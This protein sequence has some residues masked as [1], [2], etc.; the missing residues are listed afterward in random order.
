MGVAPQHHHSHDE[1]YPRIKRATRQHSRYVSQLWFRYLSKTTEPNIAHCAV[2]W[3]W[4]LLD[5]AERAVFGWVDI[6]H[7]AVFRQGGTLY[8]VQCCSQMLIVAMAWTGVVATPWRAPDLRSA[9]S[10]G[11]VGAQPSRKVGQGFGG[12]LRCEPNSSDSGLHSRYRAS[13]YGR[14]EDTVVSNVLATSMYL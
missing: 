8:N 2:F 10:E 13:R 6:A 9:A 3:P 1:R 4:G 12:V 11:N 5:I 14:N 7:C